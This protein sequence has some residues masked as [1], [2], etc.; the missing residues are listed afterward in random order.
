MPIIK[1]HT[2]LTTDNCLEKNKNNQNN[3]EK[4]LTKKHNNVPPSKTYNAQL[5]ALYKY[6]QSQ[7]KE[8]ANQKDIKMYT[9]S[10]KNILR[11]LEMLTVK[12]N[13]C[14][15]RPFELQ[16][17]K[18]IS[19]EKELLHLQKNPI[20]LQ[21]ELSQQKRTLQKMKTEDIEKV[22][23]NFLIANDIYCCK[24]HAQQH[25]KQLGSTTFIKSIPDE[26]N[27]FDLRM[28][29]SRNITFNMSKNNHSYTTDTLKVTI[30]AN[31]REYQTNNIF[32]TKLEE[33]SIESTHAKK[34]RLKYSKKIYNKT[35]NFI[36]ACTY[37]LV[38]NLL[39]HEGKIQIL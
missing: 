29:H 38:K 5:N 30:N 25:K 32:S 34:D 22:L 35:D 12:Q 8:N 11:T 20:A 1:K 23:N 13:Q 10:C 3:P 24:A 36:N 16:E 39:Q 4:D 9:N 31:Y 17:I 27:I 37:I 33:W 6:L 26:L 28:Y 15:T 19:F 2:K 14:K 7:T 21:K 18:E